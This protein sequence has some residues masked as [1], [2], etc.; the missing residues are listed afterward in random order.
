MFPRLVIIVW[1]TYLEN[2]ESALGE[3]GFHEITPHPI[4]L[5]GHIHGQVTL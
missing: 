5:N 4:Y 3:T 2:K 1:I